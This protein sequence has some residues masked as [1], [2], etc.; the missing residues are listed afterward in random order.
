VQ[1][2]RRV[3]GVAGQPGVGQAGAVGQ[4]LVV[5]REPEELGEARLARAIEPGDPRR[6]ELG[7]AGLVELADDVGQQ[8]DVVLVDAL[9]AVMKVAHGPAAGDD[10]LADLVRLSFCGQLLMK[11][12]DRWDVAGDVGSE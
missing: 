6:G 10:V 3:R 5:E 4:A 1:V 12:D 11:I 2:G 9:L 8:P 7:A